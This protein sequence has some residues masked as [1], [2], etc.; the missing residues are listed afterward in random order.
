MGRHRPKGAAKKRS[1]GWYR[2]GPPGYGEWQSRAC[3]VSWLRAW[4]VLD[5]VAPHPGAAQAVRWP[6]AWAA[7]HAGKLCARQQVLRAGAVG[8]AH[9]VCMVHRPC[10]CVPRMQAMHAGR[11]R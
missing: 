9:W 6:R 5:T 1:N 3:Q 11:A 2:G 8:T 4:H 10:A 7:S